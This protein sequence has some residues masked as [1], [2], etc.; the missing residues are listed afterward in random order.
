MD[1]RLFGNHEHGGIALRLGDDRILLGS[2]SF[3]GLLNNGL[4]LILGIFLGNGG[5]FLGRRPF[6]CLRQ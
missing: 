3:D 1:D 6:P 5:G 2:R 4:C